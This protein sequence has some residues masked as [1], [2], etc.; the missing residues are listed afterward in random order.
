MLY[1]SFFFHSVE[2]VNYNV[3]LKTEEKNFGEL[4]IIMNGLEVDMRNYPK[5]N[6]HTGM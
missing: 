6:D 2:N 4:V 1:L 5:K 3:E